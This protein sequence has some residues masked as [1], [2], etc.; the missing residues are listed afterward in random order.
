MC[1][2][3]FFWCFFFFWL[4]EEII[5]WTIVEC[6]RSYILI[7]FFSSTS[8]GFLHYSLGYNRALCVRAGLWTAVFA[9]GLGSAEVYCVGISSSVSRLKGLVKDKNTVNKK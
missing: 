1:G 9:A 4:S 5:F 3:G 6:C 7:L 2:F 8:V